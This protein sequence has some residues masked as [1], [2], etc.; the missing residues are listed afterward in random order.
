M[1]PGR[2]FVPGQ[3]VILAL[4]LTAC[5]AQPPVTTAVSYRYAPAAADIGSYRVEFVDMPEFL[6]PMLRDEVSRVLAGHGLGYTE[7]EADALLLMTFDNQPLPSAVARSG[8]D[9][10]GVAATE[11]VVAA[12]FNAVVILELSNTV[13]AER[14]WS[15]SL[16][17]VH[18]VTEGAYMHEEPARRAMRDALRR[19]FADFPTAFDREGAPD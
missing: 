6:K 13:T 19:I 12:R 5:A 15:G 9:T 3:G 8:S 7:S 4:V 1:K 17:R 10:E 16:G 11:Q 14:I 18:Y 2:S